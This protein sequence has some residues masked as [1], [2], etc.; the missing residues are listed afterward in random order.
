MNQH[1]FSIVNIT[2]QF[3]IKLRFGVIYLKNID[4][5]TY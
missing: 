3:V 4:Y 2:E 1:L 5:K